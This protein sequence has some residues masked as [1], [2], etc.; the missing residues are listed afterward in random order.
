M[1]ATMQDACREYAESVGRIFAE[2]GIEQQAWILTDYD[3]LLAVSKKYVNWD[4][5]ENDG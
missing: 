3:N 1:L 5:G 2:R 4:F